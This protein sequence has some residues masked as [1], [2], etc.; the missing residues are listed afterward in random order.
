MQYTSPPPAHLPLPPYH[1]QPHSRFDSPPTILRPAPTHHTKR[2]RP[3]SE[4]IDD[5][6]TRRSPPSSATRQSSVESSRKRRR[7]SHN[8]LSPSRAASRGSHS[9]TMHDS[10]RSTHSSIRSDSSEYSPRARTS[11]AIGSLL[12]SD[13]SRVDV[14][15]REHD[16]DRRVNGYISPPSSLG[17]ISV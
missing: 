7:T 8:S 6:P 5:M 4:A 11:M 12:S 3:R 17:P 16:S 14:Y 2:S 1:M 13:S 9:T 15:R 10:P